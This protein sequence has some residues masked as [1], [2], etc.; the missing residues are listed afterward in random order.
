[1][2]L[3]AVAAMA[4]NRV[5]GKNNSLPWHIPE[6]LKLFREITKNKILIMGRKT[7]ESL[8]KP[9]PGRFHIVVTR[10]KNY[11]MPERF[12][13]VLVN[14]LDPTQV[15]FASADSLDHAFSLADSMMPTWPEEVCLLGGAE[16]YQQSLNK[17]DRLY[18]SV[19]DQEF[20]G[21]ARFPDFANSGLALKSEQAYPATIPFTLKTYFRV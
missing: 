1:M 9:L 12:R 14:P 15:L 16:I 21:D 13:G 18:L 6:E 3:S 2:I 4:K 17:L 11:Q 7:F 5:I 20:E 10:Q 8:P 19:I